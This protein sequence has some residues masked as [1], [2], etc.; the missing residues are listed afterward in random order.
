MAY[1]GFGK[2]PTNE[3][4]DLCI[5]IFYDSKVFLKAIGDKINF[6]HLLAN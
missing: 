3:Y 6:V 4:S 1:G 5:N 2:I